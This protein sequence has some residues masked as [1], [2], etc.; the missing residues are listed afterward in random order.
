MPFTIS[1]AA[2]VLPLRRTGLP[3]A[4]LMIGSMSPDFAYFVLP[5]IDSFWTHSA[6]GLFLFCWP[7]SLV[8]WCVYV[9]W[10]EWPTFALLPHRWRAAFT[11]SEPRIGFAALALASAAVILGAATHIAWDS[12]TH[13]GTPVVSAAPALGATLFS[14][15]GIPVRVFTLLQHLSTAIGLAALFIWALRRRRESAAVAAAPWPA[16]PHA[17]RL[18]AWAPLFASTFALAVIAYAGNPEVELGRR[19]F[20]FAVGG[21]KGGALAWIAIALWVRFSGKRP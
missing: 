17:S 2:A 6:G 15:R 19:L 12:F 8:V 20:H 7:V 1:H 3:L 13:A 9:R 11:P 18:V 10:I 16:I 21:M 5:R 14:F 4:A